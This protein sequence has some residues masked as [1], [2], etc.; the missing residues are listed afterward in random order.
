MRIRFME[1]VR[2]INVFCGLLKHIWKK[3]ID[4][5]K[6]ELKSADVYLR[7][8]DKESDEMLEFCFGD[9]KDH[10]DKVAYYEYRFKKYK[11]AKNK[12]LLDE[13]KLVEDEKMGSGNYD[14]CDSVYLY[15]LSRTPVTLVMG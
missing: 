12:I 5:D 11:T 9:G 8:R 2:N 4:E 7:I 14:D 13:I 3:L 10:S 15:E 1:G 6:Y